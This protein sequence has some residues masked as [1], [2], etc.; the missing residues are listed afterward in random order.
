MHIIIHLI[1]PFSLFQLLGEEG[2]AA[3]AA[4]PEVDPDGNRADPSE[5]DHAEHLLAQ[6][7]QM[8]VFFNINKYKNF[9]IQIK[10]AYY[11]LFCI[12]MLS[13]SPQTAEGF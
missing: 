2:P 12:Q 9:K 7:L 11:V 10:L 4:P 1:T 8:Y 6:D 5:A 3:G 13:D